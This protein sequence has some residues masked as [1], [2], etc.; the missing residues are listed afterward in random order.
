[1]FFT[2]LVLL[3]EELPHVRIFPDNP[4]AL[5]D[6]FFQSAYAKEKPEARQVN[7]LA[8]I[9]KALPMRTTKQNPLGNSAKKRKQPGSSQLEPSNLTAAQPQQHLASQARRA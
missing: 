3:A 2:A 7:K 4:R 5:P 1:M 9:A 6:N 8:M